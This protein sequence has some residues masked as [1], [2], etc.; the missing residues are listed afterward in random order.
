MNDAYLVQ[1][2]AILTVLE[3]YI[4]FN[5]CLNR[6]EMAALAGIS[7]PAKPPATPDAELEALKQ[8][9]APD[10]PPKPKPVK[11]ELDKIGFMHHSNPYPY[12]PEV[13]HD[14]LP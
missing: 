6:E 9:L 4:I 1:R 5:D 13:S 12:G 11:Y 8:V 7:L 3:R 2:D 14:P 10:A